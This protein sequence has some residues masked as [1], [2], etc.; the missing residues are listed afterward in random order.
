VCWWEEGG[1][2]SVIFQPSNVN[3]LLSWSIK[4][5]SAEFSSH[6]PR[7]LLPPPTFRIQHTSARPAIISRS[8]NEKYKARISIFVNYSSLALHFMPVQDDTP[9]LVDAP[10]AR[11]HSPGAFHSILCSNAALSA[12]VEWVLLARRDRE[13][14]AGAEELK[15]ADED[16]SQTKIA[17]RSA[18]FQIGL[19]CPSGHSMT[20]GGVEHPFGKMAYLKYSKQQLICNCRSLTFVRPKNAHSNWVELQLDRFSMSLQSKVISELE[21]PQN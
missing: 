16:S 19:T 1:L 20:S 10:F 11:L 8:R 5:S 21:F 3:F 15:G 4:C 12:T 6:Q 7:Q 9:S 13:E 2:C 17:L 14:V 18:S